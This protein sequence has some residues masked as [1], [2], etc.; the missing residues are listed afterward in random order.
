MFFASTPDLPTSLVLCLQR[1]TTALGALDALAI[2]TE[3]C[4]GGINDMSESTSTQAGPSPIILAAG[5]V[6]ALIG[7][8]CLYRM[9]LSPKKKDDSV[10]MVDTQ[11]RPKSMGTEF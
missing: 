11:H 4:A 9:C 6:V 1:Y 7:S 10:Q 2:N 8:V 3:A 5:L